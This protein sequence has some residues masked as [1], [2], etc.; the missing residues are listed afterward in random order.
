M[1]ARTL[2]KEAE[3]AKQGSTSFNRYADPMQQVVFDFCNNIGELKS[4]VE[5]YQELRWPTLYTD[6]A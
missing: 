4:L 6:E 1:V 5:S 3:A 2:A